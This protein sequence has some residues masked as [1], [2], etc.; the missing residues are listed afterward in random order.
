MLLVLNV[1]Y[2]N[3]YFVVLFQTWFLCNIVY[4]CLAMQNYSQLQVRVGVRV[5]VRIEVRVKVQVRVGL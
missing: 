4:D 1:Y 2:N 3:I 5:K